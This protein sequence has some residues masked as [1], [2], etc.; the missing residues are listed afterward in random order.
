M[1]P[2]PNTRHQRILGR[3]HLLVGNWLEAHP[4]GQLFFA[5]FDVVFSN[6]DVVDPDLLYLSN[7]RAATVLTVS[8]WPASRSWWSRSARPARAAATKR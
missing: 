5:P 4:V 2:S 1:T 6:F 8:T 3:L 7:E